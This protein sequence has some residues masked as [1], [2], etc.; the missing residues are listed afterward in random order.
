MPVIYSQLQETS[1]K[2]G[3]EGDER[4]NHKEQLVWK[5]IQSPKKPQVFTHTGF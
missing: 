3:I 1:A 5:Q 2:I 4:T